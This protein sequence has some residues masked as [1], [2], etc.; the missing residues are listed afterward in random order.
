MLRFICGNTGGGKSTFATG[1]LIDELRQTTRPIITNLALRLNPWV[2]KKGHAQMGLLEYLRFTYQKTFDAERRIIFLEPNQVQRFFAVRAV[3]PA[4][5][6]IQVITLDRAPDGRFHFDGTYTGCAYFIDEAHEY[7][8]QKDWNKLGD[9]TISWS[10]QNRRCGDDAWMLSQKP[11]LVAV[12]FRDLSTDCYHMVNRAYSR[13]LLWKQPDVITYEQFV[14]TPPA[15]NEPCVRFG[16]LRW[17]RR[18]LQQCFDTAA[19]AGVSG[20]I[21]DLGQ[22][23]KGLPWWT[24]P[25][26]LLLIVLAGGVLLRACTA[27][28]NRAV[29]GVGKPIRAGQVVPIRSNSAPIP[30]AAL[31][32][33]PKPH[34]SNEHPVPARTNRPSVAAALGISNHA[35]NVYVMGTAHGQAGWAVSWSD[36][37]VSRARTVE[38]LGRELLIDG[39]FYQRSNGQNKPR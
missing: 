14:T 10:S 23:A 25:I 20:T 22:G 33:T 39:V 28:I 32:A 16:S 26:G 6:P 21:A 9:E 4:E 1:L 2:D 11:K 8:R 27:I 34:V 18:L 38:D 7:F 12:Q 5:G 30:P 19:G 17:P 35:T 13:F 3:I 31:P 24:I 36:G 37:T 15:P 29:G